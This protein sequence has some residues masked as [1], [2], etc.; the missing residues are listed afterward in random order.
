ML[1]RVQKYIRDNGLLEPGARVLVCVS[2]GAD[3]IALWDVLRRAGYECIVAHCNF[4]LRGEESDRDEAFVRSA[5]IGNGQLAM[6]E[7][8]EAKGERQEAGDIFV[9]DFD[10]QRY[11]T[12]KGISI[13]MAARELRYQW[14]AQLAEE[15]GCQAIA[16]AHHQNDQAETVLLNLKR[17]TGL[18]GLCGM[19][20]KSDNPMGGTVPV[21]RPLLCTTR[22]Y[23]EHYLRDIR[24]IAWVND[25]TNSDTTI[26]R[27]AVRAQLANYTKA[28]IEHIAATAEHLQGYVDWLEQQDT[29][30]AGKVQLYEQL[31]EY[32]FPEVEKIYNALQKG[33]GGKTFYA[34]HHKATIKKGKVVIEQLK[35][36]MKRYGIIGKPLE[37]SYSARYFT[38]KFMRE[39]INAEYQ[40]YEVDDLTHIPTL[41]HDLHGFNVTY[42][43]KQAIMPLLHDIDSVAHEIGAV[44][45]VCQGKG[46]NTDWIGF[47][48][49]IQPHL[50]AHDTKAL[51]LGTGGV[52]KAVQYALRQMGIPYTLVSR[53]PNEH[54]LGY[55]Q[56]SQE[57][58]QAHTIIIN[59]TPLG[60]LPAVESLPPIPYQYLTQQHLLYD[61]V[62]NP[63]CTAFLR[64]GKKHGARTINGLAMLHAQADAAWEIWKNE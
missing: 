27:N 6:G 57:V 39:G 62:Y 14:F 50:L 4:H 30:A 12:E 10:T 61:C 58:I 37:H 40:L 54:I 25:S 5:A 9:K 17:G 53:Y 36:Q 2:G 21:I 13:E 22:D 56:L 1:R 20:P 63:A 33:E 11:A 55:E 26:T 31:R 52:S 23:I 34:P 42:P 24:H 48:Q 46:Y 29:P 43:Y 3:S 45:V 60:M 28:E 49:S 16:V 64:E 18:R 8:Q 35:A 15:Q 41:L 7:R 59:C 32:H 44:N 19:R 47:Q 51:L 38:E